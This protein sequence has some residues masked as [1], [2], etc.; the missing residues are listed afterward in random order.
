MWVHIGFKGTLL[1][2]FFSFG[3]RLGIVNS[4]IISVSVGGLRVGSN[5]QTAGTARPTP[6]NLEN[7]K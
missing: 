7:P 4:D 1:G 3:F 6:E 2:L 5:W